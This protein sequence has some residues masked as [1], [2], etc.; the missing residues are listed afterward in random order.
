M[1]STLVSFVGLRDPYFNEP[2]ED[3]R[4]KGPVL[5]VLDEQKFQRVVLFGRL[6]RR[7]QLDRTRAA[8]RELHPKITVD[9]QEL[10]LADAT[11]HPRILAALRPAL[12]KLK[13]AS[14]EEDF[15]V[16][17]L[18]GTPET[19]AC[20]VLLV[21]AGEFP[22]RLLNFRRTV[23]RGMAGPRL[24]RELDWSEPLAAVSPETLAVLAARRDR[25]DDPELQGPAAN[26]PRHYFIR[27]SIDQ[28]VQLGRHTAPLLIVGEPGTQKQHFAGFIHQVSPRQAGPLLILNCALLPAPQFESVLFGEERDEA[29][30]KLRQAEGGTLVL[31]KIQHMPADLLV[32]L[33]KAA[34]EGFSH[35]S[36]TSLPRKVNVRLIGTTDR[37]LEDEVRHGRFPADIWRRLQASMVRLPPLRERPGDVVILARDELERINRTAPRPKRFAPTALAKLESHSWPSNVSEL[38]RVIEQAAINAEGALIQSA[39]I[40]LD[41]SVNLSNV[42]AHAVP[43]IREG[44]SLEDYL[45]TIKHELVRSVLRKTM[46]NQSQAARLL[47]VTPQAVSKL[48][49]ATGQ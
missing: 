11:F 23:H 22:A 25:W 28:A 5:S 6:H 13:R 24:L 12:A 41:L 48:M 7:E 16:S 26:I 35:G 38:R 10:D 40:D 19:H 39:D 14:P 47:G 45:R 46:G 15:S 3:G 42:F 1:G 49:K 2:H 33:F 44:F 4:Q 32:R 34:D 18:S 31:I 21:A 29:T 37:D 43:R 30:G 9:A 36:K 27:R 8:I 20:W 17:L